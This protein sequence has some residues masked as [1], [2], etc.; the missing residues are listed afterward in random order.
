MSRTAITCLCLCLVAVVSGRAQTAS[1]SA[2][3]STDQTSLTALDQQ[4]QA[5][6]QA[7]VST[8]NTAA[9]EQ[10]LAKFNQLKAQRTADCAAACTEDTTAE[11]AMSQKLQTLQGEVGKPP[12]T[13]P[14]STVLEQQIRTQ[15]SQLNGLIIAAKP[16]C[17]P[18]LTGLPPGS[19]M[20]D[21]SYMILTVIY[22]PPG[23][24]GGKGA[25]SVDYADGSTTGTSVSTSDS[26]K[27]KLSISATFSGGA[28]GDDVSLGLGFTT[29]QNAT[30]KD[31]IDVTKSTKGDIKILGPGA[32][33][34]DH[35]E[36][37]IYLWL[38]PGVEVSQDGN[39]ID[40]SLIPTGTNMTIQYVEVGWLKNPTT[41]PP[42]VQTQLQSAG[43]TSTDYATILTADP[44]ANGSNGL[45][46]SRFIELSESFP[47]EPPE[48]VSDPAGSQTVTLTDETK[49]TS[50]STDT[51]S[52]GLSITATAKV[53]A[54][55]ASLQLKV[56]DSMTYTHTGSLQ[57]SQDSTQSAS[58]TIGQPAFG[59]AGPTNLLVYWDTLF[60]SFV[61]TFNPLTSESASVSGTVTD[62]SGKPVANQPL[63]I[64][65]PGLR[66]R[67]ITDAT[68]RYKVTFAPLAA[69]QQGTL[70]VG[71]T[72]VTLSVASSGAVKNVQEV[73]F[74]DIPVH[75]P[76][77][78]I[79]F[80]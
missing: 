51:A 54:V 77:H 39:S 30:Q 57:N 49:S 73:P 13:G 63:S 75:V 38:N 70:K 27:N 47:Y 66:L 24:N 64:E 16:V 71:S 53:N 62:S 48:T 59:Y 44:F 72:S 78:P 15:Q 3:L 32:D 20:I 6:S 26:F 33:G 18:P 61:F 74:A 43:I 31:Q 28:F 17:S 58:F 67:T 55:F 69:A 9:Y 45:D 65:L 1:P 41:M 37:R 46:L 34:I 5:A 50:T 60:Q 11:H 79:S 14:A 36:D 7:P 10:L 22:A 4:L 76:V 21:P 2:C 35:D 42:G 29:S 56:S 12:Y 25:S 80:Q 8:A 19:G 23:S 68:G 52:V 40:W